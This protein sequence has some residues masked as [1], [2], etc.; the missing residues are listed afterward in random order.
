MMEILPVP[1]WVKIASDYLSFSEIQV[2][3]TA[4][5]Y[6]YRNVP[7]LVYR[8]FIVNNNMLP[9]V[10]HSPI[11][12]D[13]EKREKLGRILKKYLSIQEVYVY[14]LFQNYRYSEGVSATIL[15]V[16][17]RLFNQKRRD[18]KKFKR[19]FV[20]GR[21]DENTRRC[22]FRTNWGRNGAED[23]VALGKP[24]LPGYV[25]NE[26]PAILDFRLLVEGFCDAFAIGVLPQ[27][28]DVLGILDCESDD[29]DAG[30]GG[31]TNRINQLRC[32]G[33]TDCQLCAKICKYFP[34]QN[35][36]C[37]SKYPTWLGQICLSNQHRLSI[38]AARLQ[39]HQQ[40]NTQG[41]DTT[42]SSV[43]RPSSNDESASIMNM[44]LLRSLLKQRDSLDGPVSYPEDIYTSIEFL[45][46]NMGLHLES[47]EK[48]WFMKVV[49]GSNSITDTTD[50]NNELSPIQ[51][52]ASK[53]RRQLPKI[54]NACFDRLAL[55]GFSSLDKDD[56][57][58]CY[59]V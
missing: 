45:T 15:S 31:N 33:R 56:F 40:N 34:L 3:C 28:M 23:V 41:T 59:D 36:C 25:R 44:T 8:L 22:R 24:F 7:P 4:S 17:V 12:S 18:S 16:L 42:S 26:I 39:E 53:K 2:C 6:F 57:T 20:G 58:L 32:R 27:D 55:I 19:V 11:A 9:L 30:S 13:R 48:N 35:V 54:S 43:G 1:I 51:N 46:E 52:N 47:I 29:D 50:S 21:I 49:Y 10:T 38:I 5:G 37:L 14:I